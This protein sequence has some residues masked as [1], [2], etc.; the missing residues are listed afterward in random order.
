MR[1]GDVGRFQTE[2]NSDKVVVPTDVEITAQPKWD[3]FENNHF[4]MR[5]RLVDIFLKVA[6][7]QIIRMRA[8]KRLAKIRKRFRDMGVNNREDCK[9]LVAEDWKE[10]LNVRAEGEEGEQE[11]IT[12][13]QFKFC[14]NKS[15]I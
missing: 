3:V 9:R 1:Q 4:A 13:V 10:S 2:I 14:F 11:N 8:G 6:N 15:G 12:N 7:K 5:K